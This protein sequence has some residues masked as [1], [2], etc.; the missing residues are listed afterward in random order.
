MVQCKLRKMLGGG[1][2]ED[3]RQPNAVYKFEGATVRVHGTCSNI[4]DETE[5]FLK[6]VIHIRKKGQNSATPPIM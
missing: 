5:K 2:M 4:Q 1:N 6:R 3:I